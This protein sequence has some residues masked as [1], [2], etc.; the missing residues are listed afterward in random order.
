MKTTRDSVEKEISEHYGRAHTFKLKIQSSVTNKSTITPST[1][2]WL[3]YDHPVA[4][5]TLIPS[6]LHDPKKMEASL[7]DISKDN[8][9]IKAGDR[10]QE[11]FPIQ[12]YYRW[13]D[14]TMGCTVKEK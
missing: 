7:R 5:S 8:A 1:I 14:P 12:C 3:L 11:I 9:S 10:H 2:E 4:A 6:F 13:S